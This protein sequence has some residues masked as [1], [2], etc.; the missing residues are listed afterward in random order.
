MEGNRIFIAIYLLAFFTSCWL[1]SRKK[2]LVL[3]VALSPVLLFL[4]SAWASLR[5]NLTQ[6]PDSFAKYAD[7]TYDSSIVSPLIGATE[8]MST[9][10][11][12]HVI[13]DAGNDFDYLYGQSYVRSVTSFIPRSI[14]PQKSE[15]FNLILA[16][17]YLP[18]EVT[19]VSATALGRCM[20]ISG[21]LRLCCFQF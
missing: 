13:N 2:L 14:Y 19:S 17:H 4:F 12:M 5:H 3:F 6:L 21:R 7:S 20:R 9:L 15:T 11:L 8:G 16:K 10:L 1:F 18:G